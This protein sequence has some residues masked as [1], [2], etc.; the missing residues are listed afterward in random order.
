MSSSLTVALSDLL[1]DIDF[2]DDSALDDIKDAL[3]ELTD[4]ATQLVD[5]TSICM[6]VWRNLT[7]SMASLMMVLRN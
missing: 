1:K 7:R 3:D 2:D 5:G 6:M 4:A